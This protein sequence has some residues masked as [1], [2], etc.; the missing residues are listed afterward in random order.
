MMNASQPGHR[1]IR[2]KQ[3]G[4]YDVLRRMAY[5]ATIKEHP[6]VGVFTDLAACI[7]MYPSARS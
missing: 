4:P 2:S 1:L 5:N 6:E 3:L 7:C